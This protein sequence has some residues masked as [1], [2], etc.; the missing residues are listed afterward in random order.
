MNKRFPHN[1]T[2]LNIYGD[3]LHIPSELY[4]LNKKLKRFVSLE[5]QKNKIENDIG[6]VLAKIIKTKKIAE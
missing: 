5:K 3:L 1:Y 4:S 6:Q 2:V